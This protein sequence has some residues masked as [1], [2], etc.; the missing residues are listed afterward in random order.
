[1]FINHL[2]GVPTE[3]I[4]DIS[5]MNCYKMANKKETGQLS[6]KYIHWNSDSYAHLHWQIE[7]SCKHEHSQTW[8]RTN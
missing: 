2:S 4:K 1:M 5:T 3:N 8:M 7:G 6:S